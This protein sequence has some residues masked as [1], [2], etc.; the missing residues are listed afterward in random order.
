MGC[1]AAPRHRTD[2]DVLS[3]PADVAVERLHTWAQIPPKP[4]E[5]RGRPDRVVTESLTRPRVVLLAIGAGLAVASDYYVQ[6]LLPALQRSLH[7]GGSLAG[8]TVTISQAG[9]AVG[10]MLLVPLADRVDR[11]RLILI[12]STGT[13]LAL[14]GLA[15]AQSAPQALAAAALV[16]ALSVVAMVLVSFAAG[17]AGDKQRGTVVAAVMSRVLVG[18]VAARVASG[19][20]AQLGG[21]RVVFFVAA[22]LMLGSTAS[23]AW[24]LPQ[25]PS[26]T[27]VTYQRLVA[28]TWTLIRAEPVLRWRMA[29]GA[30]AFGGFSVLWTSIAFLL[31]GPPYHYGSATIGLV[32]LVGVA[33]LVAANVAGRLA[34]AG[35]VRLTTMVAATLLFACWWPIALGRDQI[36]A[37]LAGVVVLDLAVHGLHISNQSAICALRP[38][39]RGRITSGYVLGYFA[40]GVAGSAVSAIAYAHDGWGAVCLV[41]AA[42]GLAGVVLCLVGETRG[43]VRGGRPPAR[44]EG[45]GQPGATRA[46]GR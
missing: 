3:A 18:V 32:G 44:V 14:A 15:S 36:V 25:S 20:I 46:R 5:P 35:R 17:L 21:W 7:F 43:L 31:S 26:E 12:L 41:G 38:E 34:D 28:S 6:P 29:L 27:R 16:G 33:G 2:P 9:Y 40:G 1:R 45:R 8:L 11:R 19:A 30:T 24:C 23:L 4:R 22:G 37:L 13:A 10:L 39:A 42:F